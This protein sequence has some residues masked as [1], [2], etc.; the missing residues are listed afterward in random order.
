MGGLTMF[1]KSGLRQMIRLDGLATVA[2]L[3][4]SLARATLVYA[5]YVQLKD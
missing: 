2:A 4:S 1:I 3:P 5:L